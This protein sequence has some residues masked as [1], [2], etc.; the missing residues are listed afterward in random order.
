MAKQQRGTAGAERGV[1]FF[2][3]SARYQR[4]SPLRARMVIDVIRNRRVADALDILHNTPKK[5]AR[6]VAQVVESA[7]ANAQN[8]HGAL[9]VDDLVVGQAFV[10]EGPTL[11]RWLPRAFGRAN[12]VLKRTSHITVVLEQPGGGRR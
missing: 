6:L 1:T 4:I 11:K 10:D 5:A 9:D 8:V 7:L 3:A 2:R 12:R